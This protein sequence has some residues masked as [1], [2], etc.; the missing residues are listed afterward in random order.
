MDP[1]VQPRW[2]AHL[3]SLVADSQ[4]RN[5]WNFPPG[6]WNEV[7]T[8][9]Q[10]GGTTFYKVTVHGVFPS[11]VIDVDRKEPCSQVL[12]VGSRDKQMSIKARSLAPV[13][14]NIHVLLDRG[15]LLTRAGESI[16]LGCFLGVMITVSLF[17]L[18]FRNSF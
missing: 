15:L 3:Q 16:F 2:H 14:G 10:T 4:G 13:A 6:G 17:Q 5:P 18:V 12:A 7:T 1:S 11:R 8:S 9:I